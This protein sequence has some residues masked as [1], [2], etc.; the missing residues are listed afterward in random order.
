MLY[1]HYLVRVKF[2]VL[3]LTC[4]TLLVKDRKKLNTVFC[5]Y[6]NVF[7]QTLG[8]SE[9]Q[10]SLAHCCSWGCKESDMT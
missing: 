8:D 7:E 5:I 9:G 3:L 1:L 4:N 10:G 2:D 6:L